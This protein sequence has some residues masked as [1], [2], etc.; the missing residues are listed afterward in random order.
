MQRGI[1]F[2]FDGTLVDTF[3]DIVEGVQRMRERLRAPRLAD[4]QI[5]PHIG[6]GISNLIGQCHPQLDP[7][8]P[9][10][11]PADG[12]PL[13][14]DPQKIQSARDVFREEYARFL[15]IHTRPYPGIR[16]LCSRLGAEGVPLAIVSNK[17]ELFI[18]RLLAALGMADPFA[19][20]LGGD[21]LPVLK[22]DP[23]PLHHAARTLG[24]PSDSCV[25]VGDSGLDI[26]AAQAAGL[27][28]LAVTWGLWD[29]PTLAA[30]KPTRLVRTAGE[31][32]ACIRLHLQR[33]NDHLL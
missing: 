25:M 8:R 3:D 32:E 29:R 18:R 27:P 26:A 1:L 12:S 11:L 15:I 13:P 30:L 20:V 16:S 6:W 7:L 33:A 19:L 21:S 2:D 24:L 28:S 31:L 22:P 17:P 23:E 4:D 5:R 10:R 9:D 14:V